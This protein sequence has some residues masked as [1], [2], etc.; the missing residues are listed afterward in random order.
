MKFSALIVL[1]TATVVIASP[2]A[3]SFDRSTRSIIDGH[4]DETQ[5]PCVECP[6]K[7]G[8]ETVCTC[9]PNGCCCT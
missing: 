4:G 3:V 5:S 7:H 8:F 2:A 6:C 1:V 9:I